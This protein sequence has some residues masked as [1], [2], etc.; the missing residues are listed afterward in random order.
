MEKNLE[1]IHKASLKLLV[2]LTLN[3]TYKAIIKEAT[4]LV[5]GKLG[6]IL[7]EKNGKLERVYSSHKVLYNITPRKR[8]YMYD[9]YRH[10]KPRILTASQIS[11]IHPEINIAN[12]RSDIII[13]LSHLKKQ[14]GVLTILS[15]KN[16]DF[17]EKDLA[18]LK[19]FGPLASL[20]IIKSQLYHQMEETLKTRD[21]FISLASHELKTPLTTLSV[22]TQLLRKRS[23]KNKKID[24]EWI[25]LIDDETKWL[26]ILFSELLHFD[27]VRKGNFLY[28][29]KKHN[30]NDIVKRSALH[31]KTQFPHNKLIINNTL[32]G[33]HSVYA[34]FDKLL[35]VFT[36]ILNNAGKFSSKNQTVTFSIH[37]DEGMYKFL[38]TDNGTGIQQDDLPYLYDD[39]YKGQNHTKK[40]M[41]LGL[42][43]AKEIVKKHNGNINIKSNNKETSVEIVIPEKKYG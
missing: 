37:L 19:L 10:K 14:L 23:A 4:K 3:E 35:Q 42:F 33:K 31:F 39:F 27:Q 18:V 13:P 17:T 15:G 7:L 38:I 5:N 26:N 12:I 16:K 21:L 25:A 34:D 28:T 29:W 36:N 6:S 1:R 11:H 22:Y 8:G 2:P 24:P 43:L 40:G 32:N 30:V 20:A 9:V 41:G